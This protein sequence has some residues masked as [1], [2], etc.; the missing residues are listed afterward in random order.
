MS[1][2]NSNLHLQFWESYRV[3]IARRGDCNMAYIRNIYLTSC[4]RIYIHSNGIISGRIGTLN[5]Y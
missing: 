1:I 3:R 2:K 4:G 5:S